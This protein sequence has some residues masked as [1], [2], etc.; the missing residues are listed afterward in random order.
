MRVIKL[1]PRNNAAV[2]DRVTFIDPRSRWQKFWDWMLM[3]PEIPR[4]YLIVSQ[5]SATEFEIELDRSRS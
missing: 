3:R 1:E 4:R 5:R 2:G